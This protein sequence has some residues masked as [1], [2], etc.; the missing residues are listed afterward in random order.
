MPGKKLLWWKTNEWTLRHSFTD[1]K[2]HAGSH[3]STQ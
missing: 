1:S 2:C 3:D